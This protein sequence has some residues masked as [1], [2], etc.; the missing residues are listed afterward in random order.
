MTQKETGRDVKKK[1]N[2][3]CNQYGF[4]RLQIRV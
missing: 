4:L 1:F 2:I 3:Y